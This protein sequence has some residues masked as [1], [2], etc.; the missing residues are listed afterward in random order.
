MKIEI[1]PCFKMQM[2]SLF[3]LAAFLKVDGAVKFYTE[4]TFWHQPKLQK[5]DRAITIMFEYFSF[6]F[7][8]VLGN[9]NLGLFLDFL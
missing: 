5:V 2:W 8:D 9:K 1:L 3:C 7:F 6:M 4:S